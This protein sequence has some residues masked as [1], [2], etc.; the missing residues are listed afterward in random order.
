M[1]IGDG[2]TATLKYLFATFGSY[3]GVRATKDEKDK[4]RKD[5]LKYCGLDTEGMVWILEKLNNLVKGK[6]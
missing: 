1:E 3:D 6:N 5:L 4:I 2:G